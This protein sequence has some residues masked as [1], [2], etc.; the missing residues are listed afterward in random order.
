M[1]KIKTIGV[2]F[3]GKSP[4]HDISI[5]TGQLILAELRK[6]KKYNIVPVYLSK[7]EKFFIGEELGY[8]KFFSSGEAEENLNKFG[9]YNLDLKASFKKMI[10]KRKGLFGKKIVIDLAFPAFH[11]N[12]GED[13]AI[14]GLFKVLNVPFVG[15][16][17]TSSAVAMDKALT[18]LFYQSIDVPT[19]KFLYYLRH[20]WRERK[21]NIVKEI[22]DKLHF[23]LFIKPAKLG[24]SIGISK[25]KEEK[26]LI[27]ACELAFHYDDKIV[28]EEGVEPVLDATCAVIGNNSLRA[29]LIQE[30]SFDKDLF[31]YEDKYLN[32][33]GAQLGQAQNNIFIPARLDSETTL[34]IQEYSKKIFKS[35]GCSGIARFDFLY[36][37]NSK[38]IF[39]NEINPLPGTL[40][41]HLWEKSG[42]KIDELIEKLIK[43]A[44]KKHREENKTSYS[45]NSEVLNQARGIKLQMAKKKE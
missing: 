43:M 24:S 7:E 3:G 29:S 18:K 11:G 4:E 5:I 19:T 22:K 36:N 23:P 10:F 44:F 16:G 41:H 30:S 26:D 13:G 25:V 28:V 34:K 15:C 8:L 37:K 12:L 14:Q 39:A 6:S 20:D 38:E 45:F 40:Y 31:S 1:K 42:L 9:D 2:F 35:L 27:N 21:E 17:V 33:G 32:D